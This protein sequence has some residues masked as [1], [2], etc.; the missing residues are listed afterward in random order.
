MENK[1]IKL[2]S[3]YLKLIKFNLSVAVAFSAAAGYILF[4]DAGS[5]KGLAA[6]VGGVFF[7]SGGAAALNQFQERR[8]DALMPRTRKRPLPSHELRPWSALLTALLMIAE[9]LVLLATFTGW[10]PA[11]LGLMNVVLYN[12]IYTNL[13]R[14]T[15][16]AVIPGGLVGAVPPLIGFTA[17]GGSLLA[18]QA[19]FLAG[20]MFMWQIPHFWL[21]LTCYRSEYERAGFGSF[22]KKPDEKDLKTIIPAWIVLTSIALLFAGEFGIALEGGLWFLLAGVN[23]SVTAL[24]L[25]FIPKAKEEVSEKR[26]LVVLNGFGMAVLIILMMTAVL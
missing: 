24:F 8:T 3:T 25:V 23:I 12:L 10:L 15:F 4:G 17:A 6:T 9:G 11:L 22:I 1:W 21:L 7:L 18:P 5:L 2:T 20:F 26:A 16:L 14:R 19:L 13:K